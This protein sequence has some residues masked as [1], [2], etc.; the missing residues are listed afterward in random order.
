[1]S[2]AVAAKS[3]MKLEKGAIIFYVIGFTVV[4]LLALACLLPFI[5]MIAGSFSDNGLISEQGYSLWPKGFTTYAY[6]TIF[7]NTKMILGAYKVTL[8]V[9]LL[10]TL[11][12]VL[13]I[14]MTG[15]VLSRPDFRYRY[16]YSFF[17]YF[18]TLFSGGLIPWYIITSQVL[19]L[20]NSIWALI[21]PGVMNAFFIFLFKNFMRAIPH[22]FV[23]SSRIDGA[24]DLRIFLTIMLPLAKPAIATIALFTALHYWNDWFTASLL[25]TEDGKYP[26]QFI[27]FRMLSNASAIVDTSVIREEAVPSETMKLAMALIT[28]GP[29]LLFYP[30]AQKYIVTGL[31]IGGVK[32]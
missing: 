9:T 15:F 29:V 5:M 3:K 6:E 23:E 26:L 4:T 24:S 20:K 2:Q 22:D 11:I 12:S 31:T 8:L 17:L 1:M 19:H 30:F 25:I 27:L 16:G 10:G 14:A 28:T 13:T 32:G 21:L 18:T 7:D